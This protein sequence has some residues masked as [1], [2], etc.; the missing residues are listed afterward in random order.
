MDIYQNGAWTSATLSQERIPLQALP[1]GNKL[2][3]TGDTF[4]FGSEINT[5]SIDVFDANIGWSTAILSA[6]RY[7]ARSA[8]AGNQLFIAGGLSAEG[9]PSNVVDIY[10]DLTVATGE[11]KHVPWQLYPNPSS[12]TVTVDISPAALPAHI[13]L[14]NIYGQ[15]L[16]EW[17]LTDPKTTLDLSAFTP[18]I[19]FFKNNQFPDS[20]HK[21]ILSK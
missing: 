20:F 12:G 17:T 4:I 2:F 11:P 19:Y 5:Q 10:T 7:W 13:K 14:L 18:G 21:I 1:L 3:F 15:P 6:P 9:V 8:T 16:H